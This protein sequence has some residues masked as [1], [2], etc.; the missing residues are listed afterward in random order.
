MDIRNYVD[1]RTAHG[2]CYFTLDEA[3]KKLA[4][5][6]NAISLS[7]AHLIQKGEL[8]SPARGFYVIIPPEYRILGCIPAD[9]FIPHLMSYLGRKY[10]A[11]L[12]TAASYYGAAHQ[13]PQVFQVITEKQMRPIHCGKVQI[14]FIKSLHIEEVPVTIVTSSGLKVSTPEATAMD[15]LKF[16][17]QSGGLNNVATILA[18][19]KDSIN[20]QKLKLLLEN[21]KEMAWKQRLGYIL[22]L[23]GAYDLANIIKKYID[24]QSRVDYVLLHPYQKKSSKQK[25]NTS[26]KIFENVTI[27]SDI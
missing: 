11:A 13:A 3:C 21:T 12:I 8:A 20:K 18:E 4:K 5:S 6:K 19:L 25:K 23:F 1:T 2:K 10:Y 14:Q 24:Q 22:E 16:L 27:E 26:W 17:K 9:Q 15:L 7:A